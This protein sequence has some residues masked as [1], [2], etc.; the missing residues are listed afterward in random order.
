MWFPEITRIAFFSNRFLWV[1]FIPTV[2]NA[3]QQHA[4]VAAPLYSRAGITRCLGSSLVW[5]SYTSWGNEGFMKEG[6]FTTVRQ[7]SS[8]HVYRQR[9]HPPSR[10]SK[11][12][13]RR[14][15]DSD[16]FVKLRGSY[17]HCDFLS[18]SPC[19]FFGACSRKTLRRLLSLT[20][21]SVM[22]LGSV[23]LTT[24]GSVLFFRLVNAGVGRLPVPEPARRN[25]W[26]WRNISSSFVHS[27]ITA[28]WAV[29]WWVAIKMKLSIKIN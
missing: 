7:V 2:L 3:P 14:L 11:P 21:L 16:L 8:A 15:T 12:E 22:E 5:K 26:K 1:Y 29:L 25:A 24:G 4:L 13:G 10:Q 6:G 17:W 27:L 28:I 23:I 9:K 19:C 20:S 18:G